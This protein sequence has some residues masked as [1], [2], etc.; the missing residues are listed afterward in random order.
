MPTDGPRFINKISWRNK[1]ELSVNTNTSALTAYNQLSNTQNNLAKSLQ[2]LSS[3][4]RI[5]SAA[6]DAAGLTVSEG[7]RS[8]I[9]GLNVASRNIQDGISVTQTADGALGEVQSI[10]NRMR[11]LGVQASNDTNSDAS[12]TAIK[13]ETDELGNELNRIV[14]GSSFNGIKI[15]DGTAGSASDGKMNIQVGADG[16]ATSS[17]TINLKDISTDLGAAMAVTD[18][19]GSTLTFDTS[20]NAK[21]SVTALDTAL[22][23]VS[24]QRS[25]LGATENRLQSASNTVQTATQNLTAARANI[26]DTNMAQEMANFTKHQILSQAGTA[27]LAQANQS[28]QGILS[29]LR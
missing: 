1:Y 4:L 14:K 8:Q 25:N 2:K 28:N 27:M 6:D 23:A 11:D 24:A 7:L 10:L 15:L 12:R 9:G 20:T 29:L 17:I 3:G 22:A 26:T 13:S 21:A 19:A 16:S 18:G 5:N